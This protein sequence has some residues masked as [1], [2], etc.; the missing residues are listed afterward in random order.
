LT[1]EPDTS[2]DN[3]SWQT[4]VSH[5]STHL[6][7]GLAILAMS[8]GVVLV[9]LSPP[10][11]N[12]VLIGADYLQLHSR[13]M[14]FAR[15]ALLSANFFLPAWYPGE[16][17]GTPFWSNLQNFPFIPTRLVVLLSMDPMGPYSHAVAVTLSALL[18]ALFTY[19]F[20]RKIGFGLPACAA[21][22]WTFACSGF[23]A[24]R[25][26]AG[27][28]PLL[29][30]YP[31]LP[32]LLW[33]VES[34]IQQR[35]CG[36]STRRWIAA[37]AVCSACVMLAGHP[38]L[39]VYA[40][41]ATAVYSLWRGGTGSTKPIWAGMIIGVGCS[42]FAL[43]PMAMLIRRSTRLLALAPAANDVA[44]PY[45]RLAAFFLPWRD[46]VPPLV[47]NNP[48]SA[49]RGYANLAY[50]WDTVCY[51]GIVPWIAV[52]LL[53]FSFSRN[54]LAGE[55]RKLTGLIAAL[56]LAGIIMSLPLIQQAG[57]F[58]PG[59]IFR[60]PARLLYF[61]QFALAIA[62]GSAI[63]VA[64]ATRAPIARFLVAL[65]LTVHVIDL[66]SHDRRFI[67][68]GSLL[69]AAELTEMANILQRIG[70]GRAA[71][72]RTPPL[73]LKHAVDDV[74]FFDSIMLARPYQLI[75]SLAGA[76][77]DLN[78][79]MFDG[80]ELPWRA[81]AAMGAQ[82]MFTT[83][84]R[85]DLTS[86]RKILGINIYEIPGPSRRAGFFPMDQVR[87]L[88]AEEIHRKLRDP[89]F[90]LTSELLLPADAL[91]P[92]ASAYSK[93][94]DDSY[95]VE[96]RRPDSDHIECLVETRRPGY[97]RVIESWDPG[98]SASINGLNASIVPAFDALMAVPI[99]PGRNAVRFVYR[100][101]GA[102]AGK[103]ISLLSFALL[104]GLVWA[105]RRPHNTK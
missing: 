102:L 49:F 83:T 63:Q 75:L 105:S 22:G 84:D 86:I 31:A 50:F 44:M 85:K 47:D 17:L 65:L 61:T 34:Y 74:G 6:K 93:G 60:S 40:M 3:G 14:Q 70:D 5:C 41:V 94:I 91:R 62:L 25:V 38:Q 67:Q 12:T 51:I 28:L 52:L 92:E 71:I 2:L 10:Y 89:Q 21:A 48:D 80:S 81:L 96:Y 73:P 97:L 36:E 88:P 32:L 45:G 100:T 59:T 90:E 101:P 8:L 9:Y 58:I 66:G 37:I 55:Q 13:R 20:L 24:A 11:P 95:K 78:I 104:C 1:K 79:Q 16:L 103:L 57:V 56:G 76:P 27:H 53:L 68:R 43:V 18:A 29:E 39:S 19:L 64:Y 98:W 33:L 82:V 69:P 35:R 42:A 7:G 87:Y 46:G 4:S 15:D 99:S 54:K 23:Y 26:A 30:A 77:K 72:D